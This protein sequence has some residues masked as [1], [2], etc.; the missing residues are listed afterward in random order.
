MPRNSVKAPGIENDQR[1]APDTIEQQAGSIGIDADPA[2]VSDH[3]S[4]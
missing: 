3:A 1:P 2:N 4:N